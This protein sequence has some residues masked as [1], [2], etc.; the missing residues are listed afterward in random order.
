MET[1]DTIVEVEDALKQLDLLSLKF[2]DSTRDI[3][4]AP[5]SLI[6]ELGAGDFSPVAYTDAVTFTSEGA[7]EFEDDISSVGN[8]ETLLK[9]GESYVNLLYTFRR[10]CFEL[11]PRSRPFF[12][13]RHTCICP[14]SAV[15]SL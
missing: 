13:H 3:S 11:P 14:A 6:F 8:L 1:H 7:K 4:N 12:H 9:Q 10:Y 2:S 15:L 5:A